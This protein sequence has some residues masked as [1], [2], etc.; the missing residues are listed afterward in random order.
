MST[1]AH[2]LTHYFSKIMHWLRNPYIE[3]SI[4]SF[5]I[6]FNTLMQCKQ[7]RIKGHFL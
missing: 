7:I 6:L 1:Q 2:I 3:I 5:E 4:F